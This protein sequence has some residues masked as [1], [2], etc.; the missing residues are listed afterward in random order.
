MSCRNLFLAILMFL[1]HV[2]PGKAQDIDTIRNEQIL[3]LRGYVLNA[4]RFSG[5]VR[6]SLVLDGESFHP[7]TPDAAGFAL[8]SLSAF[9]HLGIQPDAEQRVIKILNAHLGLT[10]GVTPERSADGHFIHFMNV[11]TG[12]AAPCCWD[13]SYSPIGSA[14][15]AAGAQ[16]AKRQFSGNTTIASLADQLTAS[17][18][19][20]AA[21]HPSL[22]GRIYLDMTKEGGGSGGAVR[23]WN[24]YMLVESLALRQPNNERA[25]AVKDLWLDTNSLPQISYAGIPTLTDN[26]NRFAS[27]FWVQ[28]MHFF[29]GDFRHNEEFETFFWNQRDADKMYSSDILGETFRYGLTAGVSPQ[30]Y[31]A[32]RIG[33]HPD[34]VFSPEA[35]AAWGDMDTLLQFYNEQITSTSPSYKFG[36][37]RVSETEPNWLP[38]DAGLVDHLFLLF[39]LVESID[40]DFFADRLFPAFIEGDFDQDGDVDGDDFLLWQ[41][42]GS[43]AP[44]SA[45]DLA[46]WNS[47][48]GAPFQVTPLAAVPEPAT[49]IHLLCVIGLLVVCRRNV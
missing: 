44:L 28:Q 13:D 17:I 19:F 36:M 40:P 21:I 23:P 6:D 33:D 5:L 27:G 2:S 39:G 18:D 35:V 3:R 9:N 8:V 4:I 38:N 48:Y 29:N 37:V 42:G 11:D 25:L 31:H 45:G 26:V 32:D 24:E 7:A 41:R 46:D 43:P 15:L 12:A 1:I 34:N 30:G 16:F 10:P 14:L 22:D 47:H 20:N 49:I